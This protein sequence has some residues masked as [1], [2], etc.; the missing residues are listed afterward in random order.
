MKIQEIIQMKKNEALNKIKSIVNETRIRTRYELESTMEQ[1][2]I[3]IEDVLIN[4]ES[5]INQ[6]KANDKQKRFL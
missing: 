1:K 2:Y 6:L 3:D 5:E 4:L